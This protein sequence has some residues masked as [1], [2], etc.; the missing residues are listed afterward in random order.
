MI[1]R[2]ENWKRMGNMDNEWIESNKE[3]ERE[4]WEDSGLGLR[5]QSSLT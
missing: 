2:I 3:E 5:L 4:W 1:Q